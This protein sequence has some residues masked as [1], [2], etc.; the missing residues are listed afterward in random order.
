MQRKQ[1][2]GECCVYV[3]FFAWSL[4]PSLTSPTRCV[5]VP[6][7]GSL[8]GPPLSVFE[9]NRYPQR[10][11]RGSGAEP[12]KKK[13]WVVFGG[14]MVSGFAVH[15]IGFFGPWFSNSG[16]GIRVLEVG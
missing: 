15:G 6:E 11:S 2:V 1:Q 8:L 14:I 5:P 7:G 13:N 9:Q 16:I 4:S 12:S 10:G 3:I